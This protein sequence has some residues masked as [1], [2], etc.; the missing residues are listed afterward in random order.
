MA[1][2][3][4]AL[5]RAQRAYLQQVTCSSRD[6][7][8]H[9]ACTV[10][11]K[12]TSHIGRWTPIHHGMCLPSSQLIKVPERLMFDLSDSYSTRLAP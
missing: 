12:Q 10:P 8:R 2:M 7:K 1:C 11:A 3:D 5:P 6:V 4:F 9:R